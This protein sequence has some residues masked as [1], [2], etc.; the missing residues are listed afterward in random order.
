MGIGELTAEL[1]ARKQQ[2]EY[3]LYKLLK[4]IKNVK[5]TTLGK[6]GNVLMCKRILKSQTNTSGGVP[7][8]KIGTFGGKANAYIS[9]DTFEEY[10]AKYSY[11]K[12]G[13]ILISAAGTIG[14]TVIFDGQPAY[15]QDSN[16]VWVDNDE[17]KVLNRFLFYYYK[18]QPWK[19]ST[20]GT[21]SRL[22]NNNIRDTKIPLYS[23]DE[24]YRIINILDQFDTLC[25]D[26]TTGLPAE[27]EARQKQ[28]AYYRDKLLDFKPLEKRAE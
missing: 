23:L 8:Y 6:I 27:I 12:K 1:T 7:F 28:Y 25:N 20:G 18:L 21:I 13:D 26:L 15:F 4:P 17:S 9:Q 22:Y 11:P 24:Q 16:I 5:W 10:K 14:R 3:Y 2:Y 19:A